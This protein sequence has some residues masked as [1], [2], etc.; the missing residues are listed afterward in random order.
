MKC[1]SKCGI[2]KPLEHFHV[3][4]TGKLGR[5]S[6]CKL[7]IN[8]RNAEYRLGHREHARTIERIRYSKLNKDIVN[9]SAR[10]RRHEDIL[11]KVARNLRNRVNVAFKGVGWTKPHTKDILGCT[12]LELKEH[13]Q[14]Q[15]QPGMTDDNYG[16]W[17]IDHVKP[18]SSAKTKEEMVMLCH[19]VNLQPLW[20]LDNMIKGNKT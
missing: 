14:K 2:L 13:L 11:F 3:Q 20:A 19:Y 5:V 4:K 10:Q 17:H 9:A 1:C 8:N 16:K 7:C 12:F 15:Y 6:S 18:L